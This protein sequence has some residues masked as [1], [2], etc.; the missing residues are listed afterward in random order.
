M[1]LSEIINIVMF[2]ITMVSILFA[3]WFKVRDPQIKTEKDQAINEERD[4]S[5][6][7]VLAQKEMESKASL[8]DQQ[9]KLTNEQNEKKFIE[10]GGN[11]K[12]AFAIAQNH[13]NTIETDV[14]NLT[15]N[16][17]GLCNNITKLSTIIDERIPCKK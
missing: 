12:E 13:I 9:V 10:L 1:E 11:I 16:V 4:K 2:V 5:K 8:L 3:I 15:L 6:A 7:T 17:N 14:K